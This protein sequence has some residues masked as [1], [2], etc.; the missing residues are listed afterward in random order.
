MLPPS[1]RVVKRSGAALAAL[2]FTLLLA[3]CGE[4]SFFRSSTATTAAPAE[5][6]TTTPI[7]TEGTGGRGTV[8]AEYANAVLARKVSNAAAP[9]TA[10]ALYL[11]YLA[12]GERIGANVSFEEI[13]KSAEG[14]QFLIGDV[15]YDFADVKVSPAGVE[16]VTLNGVPLSQRLAG[17]GQPVS[18]NGLSIES[19]VSYLTALGHRIV[20]LTAVNQS[21]NDVVP[22]PTL[23]EFLQ[24]N[25]NRLS[26][27]GTL[28][29]P[30]R[31]PAGGRADVAFISD[32][33]DEQPDGLL[34]YVFLSDSGQNIEVSVPLGKAEQSFFQVDEDGSVAGVLSSDIG[35]ANGSSV[36]SGEARGILAGAAGELANIVDPSTEVCVEGHADSVGSKET[37]IALSSQRAAAVRDELK[38]QGVTNNI[39]IIGHGERFA[40]GD[41]QP[42]PGS[43]RVD[44]RLEGCS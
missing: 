10:A 16:D 19:G 6:A 14:F 27:L 11:D 35:F 7:A 31:I 36:L 1:P 29:A 22:M 34:T 28:A 12:R 41:E 21:G 44:I 43:R 40:P 15:D 13:R 8:V 38:R 20:I 32:K 30:P 9:A 25:G 26:D 18:N 5:S 39:V 2:A 24:N 37:N 17:V 23:S 33:G 4:D 42:D 3:S